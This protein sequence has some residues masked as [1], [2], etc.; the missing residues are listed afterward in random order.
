MLYVINRPWFRLIA[1]AMVVLAFL[2]AVVL[3][4]KGYRYDGYR[5]AHGYTMDAPFNKEREFL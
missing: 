5:A 1:V 2:L 3:E 4:Y